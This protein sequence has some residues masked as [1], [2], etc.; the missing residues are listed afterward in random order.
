MFHY[1]KISYWLLS[2]TP[3]G[4]QS[5]TVLHAETNTREEKREGYTDT[6]SQILSEVER[7]E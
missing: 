7:L 6:N 3:S 2:D 4:Q 5:D 1:T